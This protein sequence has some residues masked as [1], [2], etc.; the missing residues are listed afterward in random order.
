MSLNVMSHL[1]F[2]FVSSWANSAAVKDPL[3]ISPHN[4]IHP[5]FNL[6][7]QI[8]IKD[9]LWK[10]VKDLNRINNNKSQDFQE[11]FFIWIQQKLQRTSLFAQKQIKTKTNQ[12]QRGNG[13][14]PCFSLWMLLMWFRKLPLDLNTFGQRPQLNCNPSKWFASTC[15]FKFVMYLE[16]FPHSRHFQTCWLLLS[17]TL[18]INGSRSL[19][20]SRNS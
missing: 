16:I 1:C 8:Q 10:Q 7:V 6:F 11:M 13:A 5:P 3:A 12:T 18:T 17:R 4:P 2:I 9:V 20:T 14:G 15:P 19:S